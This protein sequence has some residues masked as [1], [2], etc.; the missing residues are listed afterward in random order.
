M[1]TSMLVLIVAVVVIAL[2]VVIGLA[3]WASRKTR[4]RPL[5]DETKR[6]YADSWRAIEARFIEDPAAAVSEADQLCVS[7]LRE[8]GAQMDDERRVPDELTK[9]RE[10]ARVQRGQGTEE[11]RHAM[12]RYQEIVDDAVGGSLRNPESRRPEVA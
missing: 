5:P 11:L 7:L 8:R 3:L 12:L 4:L 6:R 9:A 10:E 2:A 1:H